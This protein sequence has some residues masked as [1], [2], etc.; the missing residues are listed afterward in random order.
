[1][2]AAMYKTYGRNHFWKFYLQQELG[3]RYISLDISDG[4]FLPIASA[5][6]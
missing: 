5:N 6:S 3:F 2:A 1:M 4:L